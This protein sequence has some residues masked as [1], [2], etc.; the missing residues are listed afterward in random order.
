MARSSSINKVILSVTLLPVGSI[1]PQTFRFLYSLFLYMDANFR[2]QNRM[3]SSDEK[4]PAL[5]PGW[6]YF[7]NSDRYHE[8]I[9]KYISQEEISTC[10]GFAAL[11]LANLKRRTGVRVTGVGGVVCRHEIWRP[12]GIGNLQKGERFGAFAISHCHSLMYIV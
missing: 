1:H 4:D 6:S 5:G 8:H 9:Q 2:L 10:A 12:N 7:V 11:F 3:R